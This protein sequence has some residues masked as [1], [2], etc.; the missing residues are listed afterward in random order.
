MFKKKIQ[1]ATIVALQLKGKEDDPKLIGATFNVELS[2]ALI[3][4]FD[5]AE[6]RRVL[7]DVKEGKAL[8]DGGLIIE[9]G[10][11]VCTMVDA[12]SERIRAEGLY[13]SARV[14]RPADGEAGRLSIKAKWS[15]PDD[16]LCWMRANK[17]ASIDMTIRPAK[18][19]QVG[20]G[21]DTSDERAHAAGKRN[22]LAEAAP[23]GTA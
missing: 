19:S 5:D 6:T 23:A 18:G 20:L 3:E 13:L 7:K 15:A 11:Y 10:P 9:P 1:G 2:D 22:R 4:T 17:G 16:E 21:E 14:C 12:D 8:S